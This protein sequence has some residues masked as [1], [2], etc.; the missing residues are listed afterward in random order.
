MRS[1]EYLTAMDRLRDAEAALANRERLMQAAVT[2]SGADL[3]ASI[4]ESAERCLTE[5][6]GYLG[7]LRTA[8]HSASANETVVVVDDWRRKGV[9]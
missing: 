7:E 6:R 4:H 2:V 8:L 5:A 3:R 9:S 1:P